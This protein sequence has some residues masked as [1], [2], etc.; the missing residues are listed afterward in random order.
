VFAKIGYYH[1]QHITEDLDFSFRMQQAGMRIGY[2]PGAIVYTECPTTWRSL[3]KQR[4]RWT[5]GRF[6]TFKDRKDFIF[7]RKKGHS[8]WLTCFLLPLVIVNDWIYVLKMVAKA[9]LYLYCILANDM[10]MLAVAA[11]LNTVIVT[12]A[13]SDDREDRK[14]LYLAPISWLLFNIPS[15]IEVHSV[16]MSVWGMLRKREVKWQ[17]WQRAG[18]ISK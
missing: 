5:R 6:D 17:K 18:A 3:V 8:K 15:I 12:I 10:E 9:A 13:L 4:L 14:Y 11:V 1:K 7:S 2:A 16:I